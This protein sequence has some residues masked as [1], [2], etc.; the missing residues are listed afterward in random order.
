M[1]KF[2]HYDSKSINTHVMMF[3]QEMGT[4]VNIW[5]IEKYNTK[6][7]DFSIKMNIPETTKKKT[8]TSKKMIKELVDIANDLI[9]EHKD[10]IDKNKIISI[11]F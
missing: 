7:K 8:I 4:Y 5:N 3:V 11:T 9:K 6:S 1:I 10:E 2:F